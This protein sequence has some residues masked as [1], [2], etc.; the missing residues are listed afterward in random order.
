MIARLTQSS[1]LHSYEDSIF[2]Y[3]TAGMQI[4]LRMKPNTEILLF[5][6]AEIFAQ[7]LLR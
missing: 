6:E 4:H 5:T 1:H 2:L 3:V 7:A